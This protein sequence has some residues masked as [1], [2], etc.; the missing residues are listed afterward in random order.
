MP[1]K[2]VNYTS[3][4]V[5]SLTAATNGAGLALSHSSLF[6]MAGKTGQLVRPFDGQVKMRER[7]FLS[8]VSEKEQ[9]PATRAF[10]DWMASQS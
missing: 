10:L 5:V 2:S 7:Y 3:T 9:T 1:E 6:G 8:E 4:V